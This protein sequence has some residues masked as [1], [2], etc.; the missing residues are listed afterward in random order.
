MSAD[1]EPFHQAVQLKGERVACRKG[2]KDEES[3]SS[4]AS[5]TNSDDGNNLLEVWSSMHV[6]CLLTHIECPQLSVCNA[7]AC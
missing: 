2:S 4:A 6:T 1:A 7:Y 5:T 3:T